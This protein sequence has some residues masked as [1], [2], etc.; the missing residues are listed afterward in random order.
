MDLVEKGARFEEIQ[1]LQALVQQAQAARAEVESYRRETALRAP[2][3]GEV[4]K[5]VLHP[6]ELAATGYPVITLVD[7]A[8]S[9]ATFPVRE[10]LLRAV[11]VG[12]RLQVE[13][14]A[15]GRRVSMEVFHLA[16]MGDY[17][18][19][20]ATTEKKGFDL[21]SFEV[22]ARPVEPLPDLRPGMTVRWTAG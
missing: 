9:W 11:K 13:V 1:A 8:D 15:L 19:W 14:P 2:L 20:K 7:R 16:A 12:T 4:A 3:S 22:K 6:G 17:A 5:Q 21:K 10:D 18:V